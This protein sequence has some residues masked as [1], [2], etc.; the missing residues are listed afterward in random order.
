MNPSIAKEIWIPNKRIVKRVEEEEEEEEISHNSN[1]QQQEKKRRRKKRKKKKENNVVVGHSK[2][3]SGWLMTSL[4]SISRRDCIDGYLQPITMEWQRLHF[5]CKFVD[6]RLRQKEKEREKK[7]PQSRQFSNIYTIEKWI[8]LQTEL[9]TAWHTQ[10]PQPP[11]YWRSRFLF[12]FTVKTR[13]VQMQRIDDGDKKD[14]KKQ[15]EKIWRR[16]FTF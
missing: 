5:R 8:T 10:P 15:E 14:W 12:Y 9:V 4:Q 13:N 3:Q 11:S 16:T 1:M 7:T 2:C 6:D